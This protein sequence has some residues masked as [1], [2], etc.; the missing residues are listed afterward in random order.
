VLALRTDVILHL[1]QPQVRRK[2]AAAAAAAVQECCQ[3]REVVMA[4]CCINISHMCDLAS[5]RSSSS[6]SSSDNTNCKLVGSKPTCI[7]CKYMLAPHQAALPAALA[8]LLLQL[9]KHEHFT[10]VCTSVDKYVYILTHAGEAIPQPLPDRRPLP[11]GKFN[12]T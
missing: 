10:S 6:S 5:M 8:A 2:V 9:Q 12:D 4:Q 1:D 11:A 3:W 7:S